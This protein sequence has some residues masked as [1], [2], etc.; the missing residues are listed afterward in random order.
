MS[1]EFTGAPDFPEKRDRLCALGTRHG[2]DTL[3]LRAP[4]TLAWLLGARTH[5][6]QTLD[7]ACFTVLLITGTGQLTVVA[8]A[9]EAPRLRDTELAGLDADWQTVPWWESRDDRLLSGPRTGSDMPRLDEIPLTAEIARVRRVLTGRQQDQLAEVARDT[10][11]AATD[12]AHRLTPGRT[13]RAAA[14]DLAHALLERGLDPVVLLVAADERI[15]RHRHPLPT[16]RAATRRMML[17]ACGRRHGLIASITRFVSFGAPTASEQRRYERLLEVERAFL[18]SSLPGARLGAVFGAGVTAYTANG[19]P[20]DEWHRH[21]QGGFS[22][23]QPREFP[24]HHASAELLAQG[25]AVAW[26]PSGGGWKVEDTALV[27]AGG[28]RTLVHDDRW[29]TVRVGGRDRPGV[30]IR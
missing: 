21:H 11:E 24:A 15:D 1:A 26:N 14:A 3:I 6:P 29:P 20:P 13:E 12:T 22:G 7:T 18:D 16:E 4:A 27:L 2:L 19:F 28:V 17:V 23:T 9:I 10:A 5:V 30:L 25:S 8:N